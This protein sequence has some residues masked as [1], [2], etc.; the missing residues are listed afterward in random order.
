MIEHVSLGTHHFLRAV[1]FYQKVLA[2]LGVQLQRDTG[3]EAAF[4]TPAKWSFFL[5]PV[6]AETAVIGQGTHVAF[7]ANSRAEVEAVYAAALEASARDLF[8]PRRRPD[9][10]ASYFGAMFADLDG[11]RIEVLTNES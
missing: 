5:Y 1:S 6:G 10:S 11:H 3:A 7:R 8:S 2:P 4:G 9:I